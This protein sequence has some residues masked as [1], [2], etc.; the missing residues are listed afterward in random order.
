MTAWPARQMKAIGLG[1]CV[2]P[3]AT[4]A[5]HMGVKLIKTPADVYVCHFGRAAIARL[6]VMIFVV[7]NLRPRVPETMR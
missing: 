6:V 1:S 3:A 4:K 2:I 7:Q 5:V